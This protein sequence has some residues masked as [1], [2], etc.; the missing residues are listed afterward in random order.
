VIRFPVPKKTGYT[1]HFKLFGLISAGRDCGSF[2]FEISALREHIHIYLSFL[3]KL[4]TTDFEFRDITV[5]VSH[6]KAIEHLCSVLNLDRDVIRAS[7]RARDSQ[8]ADRLLAQF[9]E[10]WPNSLNCDSN[11]VAQFNFPAHVLMQIRMLE[12]KVCRPLARQ[13]DGVRC[14]L[15]LSRLTGLSYYQGPCFHIKIKTAGGETLTLADV[16]FVDW[17]QRLLTDSKKRLM[18]SAIGTELLCRSF[19][20]QPQ[21]SCENM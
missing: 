12:E 16:G 9:G 5:E 3:E 6:T 20:G 2:N 21:E 8:S 18:A 17:T 1:A 19:H 13:H 14:Q 11:D 15:N 4:S 7:V 10:K